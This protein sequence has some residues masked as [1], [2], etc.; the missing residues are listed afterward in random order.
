MA[1]QRQKRA[2]ASKSAAAEASTSTPFPAPFFSL[3]PATFTDAIAITKVVSIVLP[4]RHLCNRSVLHEALLKK[5]LHRPYEPSV[6][7]FAQQQLSQHEA[8]DGGMHG[9]GAGCALDNPAASTGSSSSSTPYVIVH[10]KST[11]I[12]SDTARQVNPRGDVQLNVMVTF[13]AARLQ[14]GICAGVAEASLFTSCMQVRVPTVA[15]SAAVAATGNTNDVATLLLGDA[16]T[17]RSGYVSPGE[18]EDRQAERGRGYTAV[19]A[20]TPPTAEPSTGNGCSTSIPENQQLRV[21]A[22]CLEDEPIIPGQTVLLISEPAAMRCIGIRPP[23]AAPGPFF[24]REKAL[25][26]AQSSNRVTEAGEDPMPKKRVRK[27]R[28]SDGDANVATPARRIVAIECAIPK[29]EEGVE[30]GGAAGT[31]GG[32]RQRAH[33]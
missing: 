20:P 3:G 5:L 27:S 29:R 23:R 28:A 25:P 14:H 9:C 10:I 33:A 8:L 32:P 2:A 18:G 19:N 4:L 1:Q 7:D 11:E 6:D 15:V 22:R 16:S 30:S 24:F 13:V 26:L 21:T 17:T 31:R 12:H